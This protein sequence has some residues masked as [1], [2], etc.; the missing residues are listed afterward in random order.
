MKWD[1]NLILKKWFRRPTPARMTSIET[2]SVWSAF[3]MQSAT[4]HMKKVSTK[5]WSGTEIWFWKNDFVVPPR[6]GWLALKKA[7]FKAHFQCSQLLPIWKEISYK[8]WCGTEIWFWKNDFVVP[9]RQGWLALKKAWFEAHF[10]YSQ[11]LPIW[12]EISYKTW[13]ETKIWFTNK[14]LSSHFV[15][16]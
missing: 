10:Q 11:L 6:Q 1:R 5:T 7:W 9:S 16:G 15:Q 4:A 8:T 14:I 3:S 13:C 2:S 12:K